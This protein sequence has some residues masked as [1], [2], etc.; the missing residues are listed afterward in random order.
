MSF[1]FNICLKI[2]KLKFSLISFLNFFHVILNSI[3]IVRIRIL[4][5]RDVIIKDFLNLSLLI[6]LN[7]I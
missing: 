5:I 6:S 4:I 7:V 3:L 1:V 2:F